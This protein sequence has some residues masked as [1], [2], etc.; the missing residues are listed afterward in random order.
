MTIIKRVYAVNMDTDSNP[1]ALTKEEEAML[2]PK[3]KK[4]KRKVS[5][6]SE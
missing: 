5:E 1:F 6:I 3:Y 2:D 4:P